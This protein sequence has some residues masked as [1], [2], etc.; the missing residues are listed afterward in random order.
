M[1]LFTG[2]PE[3]HSLPRFIVSPLP[4]FIVSPLCA[5]FCLQIENTIVWMQN[6]NNAMCGWANLNMNILNSFL[7]DKSVFH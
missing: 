1:F 3:N 6:H 2:A 5:W 7:K 4:R